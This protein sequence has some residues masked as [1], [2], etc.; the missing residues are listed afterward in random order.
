MPM[1]VVQCHLH[2]PTIAAGPGRPGENEANLRRILFA[3]CLALFCGMTAFGQ[4]AQLTGLVSDASGALI[5]Y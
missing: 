3:I 4:E 1:E 5:P 2:I